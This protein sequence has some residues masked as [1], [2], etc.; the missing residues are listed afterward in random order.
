M[1]VFVAFLNHIAK[2]VH[3]SWRSDYYGIS[4]F[5]SYFQAFRGLLLDV[6]AAWVYQI[7]FQL[8]LLLGFLLLYLVQSFRWI[9]SE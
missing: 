9:F 4:K 3:I 6:Y 7:G 8:E 2:L 5:L 1:T